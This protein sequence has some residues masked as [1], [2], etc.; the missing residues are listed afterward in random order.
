MHAQ[1]GLFVADVCHL[2]L[3]IVL[4][5]EF[6]NHLIVS[7]RSDLIIELPLIVME[8]VRLIAIAAVS[9]NCILRLLVD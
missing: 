2:M 1:L 7:V 5:F 8:D 6:L 4:H 3:L 9:L